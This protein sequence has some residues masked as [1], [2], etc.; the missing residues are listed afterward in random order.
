MRYP[1][2]ERLQRTLMF[3]PQA[4]VNLPEAARRE[5]VAVLAA[6]IAAVNRREVRGLEPRPGNARAPACSPCVL[7]FTFPERPGTSNPSCANARSAPCA[8]TR[9]DPPGRIERATRRA[10][11]RKKP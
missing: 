6:L 7:L 8:R 3:E 2:Q 11:R 10:G 4:R 5:A 9:R 1:R